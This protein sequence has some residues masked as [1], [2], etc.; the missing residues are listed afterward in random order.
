MTLRRRGQL[1]GLLR[2]LAVE[3]RESLDLL[4]LGELLIHALDLLLEARADV[5]SRDQ[6]RAIASGIPAAFASVSSFAKSGTS[7]QITYGFPVAEQHCLADDR[8]ALSFAS[9]GWGDLLAARGHEQVLG[10]P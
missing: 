10:R 1:A 3:N 7:R 5:G 9:I 8:L 2:Q 4:E 6:L